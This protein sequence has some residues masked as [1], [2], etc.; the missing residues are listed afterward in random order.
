MVDFFHTIPLRFSGLSSVYLNNC[1]GM[2]LINLDYDGDVCGHGWTNILPHQFTRP[3]LCR[4]S[5]NNYTL[6]LPLFNIQELSFL[7]KKNDYPDNF[8]SGIRVAIQHCY[9]T[10]YPVKSIGTTGFS[11]T[12]NYC[13]FS[14]F[15]LWRVGNFW[16]ISIFSSQIIPLSVSR[17]TGSYQL[18]MF[19][20]IISPYFL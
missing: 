18:S 3:Q 1:L 19:R 9:T 8:G 20:V 10:F 13:K 7:Q 4:T 17:H 15:Y 5:P 6:R 2:P 14:R 12:R 11:Y 16:I